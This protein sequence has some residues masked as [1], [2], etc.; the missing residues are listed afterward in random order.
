MDPTGIGW[1]SGVRTDDY[2]CAFF[3][4]GGRCLDAFLALIQ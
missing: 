1:G 4:E 2:A 3:Y